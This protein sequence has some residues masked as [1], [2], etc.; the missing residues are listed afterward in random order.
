MGLSIRPQRGT[1]ITENGSLQRRTES[2]TS[3]LN[4]NQ[5]KMSQD[6]DTR[7]SKSGKTRIHR[8]FLA[9]KSRQEVKQKRSGTQGEWG[10]QNVRKSYSYAQIKG[11][12]EPTERAPNIP[13]WNI[14]SDKIK[15]NWIN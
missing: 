7:C 10:G 6:Y 15:R 13:T 4:K 9:I 11:T 3:S 2:F 14:V 1:A 5:V 8:E 12:Q